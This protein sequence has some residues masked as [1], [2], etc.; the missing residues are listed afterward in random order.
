MALVIHHEVLHHAVMISVMIVAITLNRII[1]I[2]ATI[3]GMISVPPTIE[4][5][6][7]IATTI[8]VAQKLV[9]NS[10]VV[11]KLARRV[12]RLVPV[13]ALGFLWVKPHQAETQT[14]HVDITYVDTVHEVISVIFCIQVGAVW[15]MTGKTHAV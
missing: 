2:S 3:N 10:L 12:T 6:V 11:A 9:T 15:K 5:V 4:T 14:L 13:I 7:I 8:E 1:V